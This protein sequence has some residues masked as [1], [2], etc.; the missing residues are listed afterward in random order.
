MSFNDLPPVPSSTPAPPRH[1][2]LASSSPTQP[3]SPPAQPR[4]LSQLD[5][6]RLKVRLSGFTTYTFVS[7]LVFNSAL[8]LYTDWRSFIVASQMSPPAALFLVLVI[9]S[10]LLSLH[11]AVTF[12]LVPIYA[13]AAIGR[14]QD[15]VCQLFLD[16]TQPH[17]TSAF[18]A[19]I[20][21]VVF[22]L[23]AFI[24][25]TYLQVFCLPFGDP[26]KTPLWAI[27]TIYA[28]AC[29]HVVYIASSWAAVMHRAKVL[30][31]KSDAILT[32]PYPKLSAAEEPREMM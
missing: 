1:S 13:K 21:G 29:V 9:G 14:G 22:F 19:F 10:F 20:S 31:F 17:R 16:E 5:V 15:E 11:S 25:S 18:F 24:M 2:L 6:E 7:A 32:S 28:C 3:S 26:V 4:A 23:G 12:T 30:I 8:K 27:K